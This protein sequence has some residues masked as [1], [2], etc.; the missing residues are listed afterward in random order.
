[1]QSQHAVVWLDHRE[2]KIFYF[3]RDHAQELKLASSNPVDQMHKHAGTREGRRIEM[4][5]ALMNDIVR[6]LEPAAEWLITGPG[7]AKDELAKHVAR[8][9][10]VLASRIVGVES[11]DHPTDGQ[12]LALARKFFRAADRM[13]Q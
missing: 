11:A 6:A 10:H 5:V 1:M 13:Q 8:H 12:I 3:D 2:A 4:D 9:H 7:S